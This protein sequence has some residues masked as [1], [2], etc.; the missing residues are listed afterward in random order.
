MA[1]F[2][3]GHQ[4]YK[5][6]KG[7]AEPSLICTEHGIDVFEEMLLLAMAEVVADKRFSK[8]RDLAQYLYAKPKDEMDLTKFTPEQIRAYIV[9][10]NESRTA[11]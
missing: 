11:G 2:E 8:F 7:R 6:N 1:R 5:K 9:S 10:L 3:A 4:G